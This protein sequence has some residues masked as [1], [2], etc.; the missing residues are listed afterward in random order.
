[1]RTATV[2]EEITV[3]LPSGHGGK[4]A[5]GTYDVVDFGAHPDKLF[6]R[7]TGGHG[8]VQADP[9]DRTIVISEGVR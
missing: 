9:T 5:A 3:I 8:L 4:L 7:D 1:M 6:L 2:T